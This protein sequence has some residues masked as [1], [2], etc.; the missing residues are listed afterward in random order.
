MNLIIQFFGV[1]P[2]YAEYPKNELLRILGRIPFLLPNQQHQSTE[3]TETSCWVVDDKVNK[4]VQRKCQK[5]FIWNNFSNTKFADTTDCKQ[6]TES[7][8]SD[9]ATTLVHKTDKFASLSQ[10]LQHHVQNV[11]KYA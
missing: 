2:N 11:I 6:D 1:S 7:T 5:R 9:A 3:E 10:Q 8:A 4:T